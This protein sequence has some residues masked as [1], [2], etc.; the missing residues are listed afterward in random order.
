MVLTFPTITA[1]MVSASKEKILLHA[2]IH[3]TRHWAQI[4]TFVRQA[5]FTAQWSHDFLLTTALP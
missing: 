1:G 5:G 4:A 2:L 3:G